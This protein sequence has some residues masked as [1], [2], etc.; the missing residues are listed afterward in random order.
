[1]LALLVF[2]RDDSNMT[3]GQA[4][5]MYAYINQF[6]IALMSIPIAVETYARIKDTINR[7]KEPLNN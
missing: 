3:Q 1:V 7:I 6:L 5:A 4:V 2:T